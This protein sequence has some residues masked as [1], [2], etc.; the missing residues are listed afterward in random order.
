MRRGFSLVELVIVVVI[1]GFIA[2]IAVPRLSEASSRASERSFAR[3]L[4][5]F[6]DAIALYY[7][8][9]PSASLLPD[10]DT[11]EMP[12]DLEPYL[13]SR[14]WEQVT[15]LGG[16][17]D[18]EHNDAPFEAGLG[19]SYEES[20]IDERHMQTVDRLIDDGDLAT[21]S[22]QRAEEGAR[23]SRYYFDVTPNLSQAR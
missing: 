8:E 16:A 14:I 4:R 1:V 20:G 22:F 2:A 10:T 13:D 7:A 9:N 6:S 12:S 17:W 18:H 23:Y 19:V 3:N 15:P 11:G 5:V 21:G